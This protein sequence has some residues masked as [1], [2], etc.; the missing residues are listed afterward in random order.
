[1]LLAGPCCRVE[2][3]RVAFSCQGRGPIIRPRARLAEE[4]DVS[5]TR[6]KGKV[7]KR[8]ALVLL[9]MAAV[10]AT[11]GCGSLARPNWFHPG[12]AVYQQARAEQFDPYPENEPGPAIVGGRP[13]EYEKPIA[14][15]LR[16][17]GPQNGMHGSQWLP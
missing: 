12:P 1:M 6:S 15:P 10:L 13:L 14:E 8:I 11:S 5:K 3:R 9:A 4:T 17:R 16:A 2:I 7:M